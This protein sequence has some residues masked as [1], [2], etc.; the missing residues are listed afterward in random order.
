M[1][2]K[3]GINRSMRNQI[4]LNDPEGWYQS[5]YAESDTLNV[6]FGKVFKWGIKED[7]TG[8]AETSFDFDP[9]NLTEWDQKVS[10]VGGILD[11]IRKVLEKRRVDFD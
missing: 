4:L 7:G 6:E 10:E 9:E 3:V 5:L 11:K 8:A 2:Q 1:T